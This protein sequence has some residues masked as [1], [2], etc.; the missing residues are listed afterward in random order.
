[1]KLGYEERGALERIKKLKQKYPNDPQVEEAPNK[2]SHLLIERT[3][4]RLDGCPFSQVV[5]VRA[6]PHRRRPV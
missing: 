5:P 2:D 4:I 3:T 6:A 1:M